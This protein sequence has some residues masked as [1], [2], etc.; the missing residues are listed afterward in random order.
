MYKVI[1]FVL[2]IS[3]YSVLS[4]YNALIHNIIAR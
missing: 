1:Y 4:H 3:V 2:I